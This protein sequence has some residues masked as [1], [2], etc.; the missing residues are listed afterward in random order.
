MKRMFFGL[1]GALLVC[2][3]AGLGAPAAAAGGYAC[4]CNLPVSQIVS[5]G[6]QVVTTRRVIATTSVIPHIHVVDHTRVILHRRTILHR[7]IIVHRHDTIDWDI[8]VHRMNVAHR[9]QVVHRT[10]V[11]NVYENTHHTVHESRT[12]RG[13]DCNCGPG[14]ANYRGGSTWRANNR[15]VIRPRD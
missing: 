13:R 5:D 1:S 10:Q 9:F 2:G 12:V 15:A 6:T 11:K 14:E 4:G 7:E 3:V 8:T